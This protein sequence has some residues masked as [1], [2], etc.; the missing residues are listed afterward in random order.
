M[1]EYYLVIA[2]SICA[3][4]VW[5]ASGVAIAERIDPNGQIFEWVGCVAYAMLAGLMARVLIFPVGILEQTDLL[6]RT[7]AMSIGF[8]FFYSFK[9]NVAMAT[10][11]SVLTFYVFI[12]YTSR[13]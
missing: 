10:L 6:S 1:T 8:I 3:T 4:Y 12:E 11:S 9:K 13:T 5:R 7:V 2:L